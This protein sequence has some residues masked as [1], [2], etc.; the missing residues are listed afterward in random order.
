MNHEQIFMALLRMALDHAEA[1]RGFPG[2]ALAAFQ[3]VVALAWPVGQTGFMTTTDP[4]G[5]I[6]QYVAEVYD[7]E[8][9]P[10]TNAIAMA[11][12]G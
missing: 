5:T 4:V 12:R 9:M 2:K 10:I 8:A 7:G 6:E 11:E 1:K 3:R